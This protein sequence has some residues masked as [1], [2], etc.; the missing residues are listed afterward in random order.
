MV[1]VMQSE[2]EDAAWSQMSPLRGSACVGLVFFEEGCRSF[3]EDCALMVFPTKVARKDDQN[4]W[5]AVA[6]IGIPLA[7]RVRSLVLA[8]DLSVQHVGAF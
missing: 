1:V 6:V 8:L 5:L 4:A 7:M 2:L 3:G